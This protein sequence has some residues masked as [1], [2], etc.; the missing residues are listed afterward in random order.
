MLLESEMRYKPHINILFVRACNRTRS[1]CT[2][3]ILMLISTNVININ[4]ALT[5]NEG[6]FVC[7]LFLFELVTY[8]LYY[9][10]NM[11]PHTARVYSEQSG[12]Y[13]I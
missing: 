7:F 4:R 11:P 1:N 10:Y 13:Y 3:Y 2:L 8:T 6:I 9:I 12:I 5:A